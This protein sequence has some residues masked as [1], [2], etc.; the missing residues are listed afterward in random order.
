MVNNT[1]E[2]FLIMCIPGYELLRL[3]IKR[4]LSRKNVIGVKN[5]SQIKIFNFVGDFS[6]L[7]T[8]EFNL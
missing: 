6:L 3:I 8:N 4:I 7:K 2:I 1:D 5:L